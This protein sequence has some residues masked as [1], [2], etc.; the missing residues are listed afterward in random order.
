MPTLHP[1]L[2]RQLKRSGLTDYS[3]PP[4]K[5]IWL[6]V[7]E[8][9]SQAYTQADQDRYVLERSLSVSSEEMQQEIGERKQAEA[10]LQQAH[11]NLMLQNRRLNRVNEL[12][13][14]TVEQLTQTIQRGARTDELTSTLK[15]LLNEFEQMDQQKPKNGHPSVE[16]K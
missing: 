16:E 13:L 4:S 10:A 15:F 14:A 3:E 8:R 5:D 2:E 1:L 6:Q 12:F 9:I 11:E 7:L